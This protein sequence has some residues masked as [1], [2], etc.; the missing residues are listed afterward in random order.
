MGLVHEGWNSKSGR[1]ASNA[2]AIE[3]RAREARVWLRDLG[4][5]AQEEGVEDVNI[6]VVTHGGFL[7]YFTEDVCYFFLSFSVTYPP[8]P[9]K[10]KTNLLSHS[11]KIPPSSSEPAG[12]IPNSA[13]INS[14]PLTP[15]TPM[16]QCK[17]RK[18]VEKEERE[19][20]SP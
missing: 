14:G 7:H 1:W 18:K 19:P 15:A 9:P 20:R 12:P 6:V 5:R 13:R 4:M 11:G 10:L 16:P 2:P 17:K 8:N 3:K